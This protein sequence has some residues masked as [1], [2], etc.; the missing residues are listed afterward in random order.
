M[1]DITHVYDFS[2]NT[3]GTAGEDLWAYEG[4]VS[5]KPPTTNGVPSGSIGAYSNIEA[6]DETYED[7]VTTS[8]NN[9]AAQRFNFSID[10]A[11]ADIEKIN[12]TWNGIGYRGTIYGTDDGATLYIWNGT[13][14]KEL[15]NNSES[16]DET[17]TGEVTSSISS[18]INAGNVTVL[19]VQKY[20]KTGRD[21][22][23]HI[24][25]DY[26]QLVVTPD[27]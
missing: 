26:V 12:V 1:K 6:D 10:E 7:Y 20:P 19:V 13:A 3:S 27:P 23:S 11:A 9:Y 14:Y 17:L 4:Q 22:A 8:N 24:S 2:D 5:N 18:Y 21:G 25:T 16:T 15:A